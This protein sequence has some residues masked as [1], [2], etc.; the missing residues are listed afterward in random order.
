MS[1]EKGR[2][3]LALGKQWGKLYRAELTTDQIVAIISAYEAAL[4]K[5]QEYTEEQLS[6]AR[7]GYNKELAKLH[8]T[9]GGLRRSANKSTP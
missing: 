1:I 8:G 4:V 9:I 3:V 2:E 6:Q 5:A 7:E